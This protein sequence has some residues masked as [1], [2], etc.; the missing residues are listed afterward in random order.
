[1][2]MVLVWL[3]V[4]L[5]KDQKQILDILRYRAYPYRISGNFTGI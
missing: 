5:P 2:S 4:V 3:D 1:M